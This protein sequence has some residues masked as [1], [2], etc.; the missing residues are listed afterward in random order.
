MLEIMLTL[1][2]YVMSREGMRRIRHLSP[3]KKNFKMKL[4]TPTLHITNQKF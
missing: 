1:R 2:R 3:M 4:V